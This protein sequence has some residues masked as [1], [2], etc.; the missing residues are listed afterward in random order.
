MEATSP[1]IAGLQ[2]SAR[3]GR[4]R[5]S[6]SRTPEQQEVARQRYM[7]SAH[8]QA[9]VLLEKE[10]IRDRQ[11]ARQA[12]RADFEAGREARQTARLRANEP[13]TPAEQAFAARGY[14]D[15]GRDK[16]KV[17]A[18]LTITGAALQAAAPHVWETSEPGRMLTAAFNTLGSY[19]AG[20]ATNGQLDAALK[21][22]IHAN[23]VTAANRRTGEITPQRQEAANL[24]K[25]AVDQAEKMV[26]LVRTT[27]RERNG[28]APDAGKA[29]PGR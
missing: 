23:P 14:N 17:M 9:R 16:A 25:A 18:E 21:D 7:Q 19:Q 11:Q 3:P 8:F 2:F 26:V 22:L 6:S 12:D 10:K 4:A 5:S 27:D 24:W 1:A 28:P 20:K 13:D 15:F 29:G